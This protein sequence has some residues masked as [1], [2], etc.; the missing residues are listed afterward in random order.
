MMHVLIVDAF[1]NVFQ[2]RS[3]FQT[4]IYTTRVH[5]PCSCISKWIKNYSM[6]NDVLQT[7][8][9]STMR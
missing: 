5:C 4:P 8:R 9:L 2:R 6:I 1:K 7:D 3:S